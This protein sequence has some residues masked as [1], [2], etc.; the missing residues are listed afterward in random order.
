MTLDQV[1]NHAWTRKFSHTH[2]ALP[3]YRQ[4][5]LDALS[6]NFS[7]GIR[8]CILDTME[9]MGIGRKN[10][11][12]CL[13]DRKHNGV[14]TLFYLL[15]LRAENLYRKPI[16]LHGARDIHTIE[17]EEEHQTALACEQPIQIEV[18]D[19]NDLDLVCSPKKSQEDS[20]EDEDQEQIS[21]RG[22]IT[23][24]VDEV[25]ELLR[26][27]QARPYIRQ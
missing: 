26:T 15:L 2:V 19:K 21:V 5:S 10:S 24:E 7:N 25:L 13:M 18:D 8:S 22:K 6:D 4:L 16:S 1:Q 9:D 20:D 23:S 27:G 11:L 12:C 17:P 14:S 3:L